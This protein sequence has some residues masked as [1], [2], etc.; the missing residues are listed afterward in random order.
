MRRKK[1]HGNGDTIPIGQELKCLPYGGF[2]KSCWQLLTALA[3]I[4]RYWQSLTVTDSYW[5][6]QTVTVSS[7]NYKQ[8]LTFTN[9]YKQLLTVLTVTDS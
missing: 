5:Q 4:D 8:L 7:N 9:N 1:V 2:K 6:L 3:V